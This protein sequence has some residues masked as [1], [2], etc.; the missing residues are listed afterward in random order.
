MSELDW[1][2]A[3][4]DIP[5]QGLSVQRR[6]TLDELAALKSAF[7]VLSCDALDV[8][9]RI[10]AIAGGAF[11][12]DGR[13]EARV[14]QA[15]VVS[16]E[17]VPDRIVGEL[18]VEFRPDADTRPVDQDDGEEATI[19]PFANVEVERI[20]NGIIDAGRVVFE[21]VASLLNPYPRAAGSQFDWQDPRSAAPD[22]PPGAG[23]PFAKLAVLRGKKPPQS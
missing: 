1:T 21:E 16:L 7:D 20:E 14:T 23:S 10:R 11:R 6:A 19:D 5:E 15:C 8:R 4:I 9:Y 18:D 2:H 12:L 13:F 22:G 17:P 3:T